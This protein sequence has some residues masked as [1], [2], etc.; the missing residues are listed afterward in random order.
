[1]ASFKAGDRVKIVDREMTAVDIKSGLFYDYFRNLTG[2]VDRVYEDGSIC[3]KVDQDSLP[4]DVLKRH[5]EVQNAVRTRWL[6]GLG[7]EQ[8]DRLSET[9]RTVVLG[10]NIL[11]GAADLQ[12][13]GKAKPAPKP[14]AEPVEEEKPAAADNVHRPTEKDIEKAEE[15]YLKS[16][17]QKA[18]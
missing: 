10:Y 6:N 17:A 13:T 16:I 18:K 5:K 15:E 9:D 1:M 2:D 14:K 4:A 8:R 7:Q 12:P 11:V 3:V